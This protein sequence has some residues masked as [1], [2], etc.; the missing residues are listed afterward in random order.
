MTYSKN[1]DGGLDIK[2]DSGKYIRWPSNVVGYIT[3]EKLESAGFGDLSESIGAGAYTT[4]LNNGSRYTFTE[5]YDSVLYLSTWGEH[6]S[7][8]SHGTWFASHFQTI[9]KDALSSAVTIGSTIGQWYTIDGN[10]KA[11]L[12]TGWT[13]AYGGT[14]SA[15][16]LS[17]VQNVPIGAIFHSSGKILV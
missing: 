2:M 4:I 9:K 11:F 1:S 13:Y 6:P 10:F 3:K 16:R 8:E 12:I 15:V 5:A 17:L 7:D 14:Y